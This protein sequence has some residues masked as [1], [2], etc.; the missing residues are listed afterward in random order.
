MSRFL[1]DFAEFIKNNDGRV[2]SICE[3]IG[4]NDP[5][6]LVIQGNNASQN[7]YSISKIYTV[8]AIGILCDRG[9]LST[10]NTVTEILGE[11]CPKGYEP[12]WEETTVDL[13][14]R[15]RTGIT[16]GFDVDVFD[17]S[18]YNPDYLK[19]IMLKK[20]TCPP[21][22]KKHYEDAHYYILSRIVH[23]VSGKTLLEFCWENIFLPLGFKEAAWSCCPKGHQIGATELY[24][25]VEDMTK[26]GAVYLNGGEYRGKRIVSD[27]WVKTVIGR[28]Y[29]FA[30]NGIKDSYNKG[31]MNGQN[32]VVIPSENRVV[33][34]QGYDTRQ[35][36][37]DLT[38]F[39]AEY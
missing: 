39:V 13:L 16:G 26:L 24:I 30:P 37:P 33:G 38:R 36:P 7:I 28:Q 1:E 34:W 10:D 19:E 9:L 2:F 3:I 31:G 21:D 22:T 27:E 29:E 14:I 12:F 11:D 32:L 6:K 5:E 23:K 15:H 20:W 25:R 8:T 4:N 35:N 17:A 18:E